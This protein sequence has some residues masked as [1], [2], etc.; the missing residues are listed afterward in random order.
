M[1]RKRGTPEISICYL[2]V[3]GLR[4]DDGSALPYSKIGISDNVE[5][6]IKGIATS[7]PFE[8]FC[9]FRRPFESRRSALDAEIFMHS[10]L[11][12]FRRRLEWFDI[13]PDD[14]KAEV[15]REFGRP[16]WRLQMCVDGTTRSIPRSLSS[17]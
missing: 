12:D 15:L 9:A 14:A 7:Q 1:G 11:Y 13:H 10:K 4:D 17:A 6:R 3:I 8:V 5:R 2:Y 16:S